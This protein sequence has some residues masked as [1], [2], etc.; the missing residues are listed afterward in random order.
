MAAGNDAAP[1]GDLSCTASEDLRQNCGREVLGKADNVQREQDFR[2]HRIDVAHCVGCGNGAVRE[3]VVD[4]RRKEVEREDDSEVVA[5]AV[6]GCVVEPVEAQEK[7]RIFLGPERLGQWAQDLR[8]EGDARLARSASAG[9][10]GGQAHLFSRHRYS[11]RAT[12]VEAAASCIASV[13]LYNE[14]RGID[15]KDRVIQSGEREDVEP[16]MPKEVIELLAA[17]HGELP[18]RPRRDPLDELVLGVLSQNTSDVNSDRAFAH[19]KRAFPT[20]QS[21]VEAPTSRVED[22]IRPGGLA[23]TKSLRLKAMLAEVLRRRGS[24]DLSFL[25]EKP[26]DEAEAWLTSLPGVGPKTA[27]V[28]LLFSLG[29]L[30]FPVDTH[31]H[32]VLR[33]LGLAPPGASAT[34]AQAMWEPRLRPDEVYPFHLYL[35]L[36]GRRTCVAR[37]PRCPACNLRRRCPSAKVFHPELGAAAAP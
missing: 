8:Q 23:P 10:E 30:A 32:R 18:Q 17:Q 21:V 6:D 22:A 28:V 34:Q 29:R 5:D 7:V 20:W 4:D 9:G 36:H 37:R 27:A 31:V 35:I 19:L 16:L 2:A 13:R 24:F 3:G 33:R 15:R 26:L 1:L 12:G 14:V 25:G 11:F